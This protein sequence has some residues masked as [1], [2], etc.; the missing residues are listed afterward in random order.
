MFEVVEDALRFATEH[1]GARPDHYVNQSM[2][3]DEY[4]D[5]YYPSMTTASSEGRG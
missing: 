1:L 3:Q 4:E 2:V 5:R